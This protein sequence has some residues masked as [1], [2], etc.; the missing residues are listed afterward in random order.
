MI[1]IKTRQ[2]YLK[3]LD[4]LSKMF[5]N[6]IENEKEFLDLCDAVEKYEEEYFPIK[7]KKK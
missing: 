6:T 1:K 7:S 3:A 4:K 2:E 5:S